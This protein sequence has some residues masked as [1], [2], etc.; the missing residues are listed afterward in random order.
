[1]AQANADNVIAF[2]RKHISVSLAPWQEQYLCRLY[3]GDPVPQVDETGD[4]DETNYCEEDPVDTE[5]ID[6]DVLFPVAR[7]RPPV[8]PQDQYTFYSGSPG[9]HSV[10]LRPGT[11]YSVV[12]G[13]GSSEHPGSVQIWEDETEE[14]SVPAREVLTAALDR[15]AQRLAEYDAAVAAYGEEPQKD[16]A[17]IRFRK[18][19]PR[20]PF[21]YSYAAIKADGVWYVTGNRRQ[22]SNGVSWDELVKFLIEGA[23]AQDFK[24]CAKTG[25]PAD[26]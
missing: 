9:Q 15:A 22:F 24:V 23:P 11:T 1:M 18:W 7:R 2:A 6:E 13:G 17:V 26:G 14:T 25:W 16:G 10:S 4:F 8:R 19:F 12:A 20:S 5:G 3:S 21:R